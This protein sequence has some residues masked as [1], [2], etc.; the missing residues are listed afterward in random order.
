MPCRH[1]QPAG[2]PQT[3]HERGAQAAA[4]RILRPAAG[5]LLLFRLRLGCR[6][7]PRLGCQLALVAILLASLAAAA[8]GR[9][10]LAAGAARGPAGLGLWLG[11]GRLLATIGPLEAL[12]W[13]N[14]N[15]GAWMGE[16][17]AEAVQ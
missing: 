4:D 6:L 1:C 12:L 17:R 3:H 13:Q 7:A 16:P 2:R 8:L 14:P 9:G 15:R 11:G 10:R 5:L